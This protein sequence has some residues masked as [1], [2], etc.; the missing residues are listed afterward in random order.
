MDLSTSLA[1]GRSCLELVGLLSNERDRQKAAAI[2]IDLTNKI[3]ALQSQL[4]EVFST[5][6]EKDALVSTLSNRVRELES[7]ESEKA[8]YELA[9]LGSLGEFLAYRLRS[10]AELSERTT[11]P[12]HFLCQ[13]CFDAGKKSVL[14][15][16][17]YGA[18]CPLCKVTGT[19][20]H[21]VIKDRHGHEW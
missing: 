3:L 11:E 10:S 15:V 2:Q 13:P 18:T 8:R 12:Q 5:V 21:P 14:H 20:A 1:V 16:G 6:V 4:L 9:K 19:L 7:H 17:Q